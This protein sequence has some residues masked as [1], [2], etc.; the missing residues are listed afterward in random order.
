MNKPILFT[1]VETADILRV[2][3][4][5]LYRERNE[6]RLTVTKIGGCVRITESELRRY[7]NDQAENPRRV[8]LDADRSEPPARRMSP[9]EELDALTT[10][11]NRR[12]ADSAPRSSTKTASELVKS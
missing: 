2:S 6:N 1:L 8:A 5:T 11:L 9:A 4:R 12:R 7:I 3:T 10:S